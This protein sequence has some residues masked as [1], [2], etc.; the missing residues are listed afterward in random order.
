LTLSGLRVVI[1]QATKFFI[2]AAAR[3]VNPKR[4][5]YSYASNC[6]NE[7]SHHIYDA[8]LLYQVTGEYLIIEEKVTEELRE[9]R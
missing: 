9:L 3:T 8:G 4:T 2:E 5:L 6:K 1:S 7:S